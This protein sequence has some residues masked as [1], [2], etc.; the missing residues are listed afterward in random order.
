VVAPVAAA[1]AAITTIPAASAALLGVVPSLPL[2]P[3]VVTS[4]CVVS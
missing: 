3:A 2:R 1:T 4:L